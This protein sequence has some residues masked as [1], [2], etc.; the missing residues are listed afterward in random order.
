MCTVTMPSAAPAAPEPVDKAPTADNVDEAMG[1]SESTIDSGEPIRA[2][3][4]PIM[5]DTTT[6]LEKNMFADV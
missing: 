3:A 5:A 6:D 4:K 1:D 2:A